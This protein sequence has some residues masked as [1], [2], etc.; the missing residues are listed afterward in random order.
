MAFETK[1]VVPLDQHFGIDGAM[2]L[3]AD[4]APLAQGLMDKNKWPH[5]L[6]VALR[7]SL[8]QSSHHQTSAPFVNVHP[9]GVVALDA[10]HFAFEN[11]VVLWH[12]DLRLS[13]QMTLE[14]RSGVAAGIDDEA[15]N[16]SACRHMPAARAVT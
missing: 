7:A 1:V 4:G 11:G 14:T 16:S 8:V 5:L 12:V 10:I 15:A 6:P 13:L 9:M 2:R 3:M